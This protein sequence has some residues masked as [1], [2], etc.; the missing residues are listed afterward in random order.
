LTY[1]PQV[2]D[3]VDNLGLVKAEGLLG[4]EGVEQPQELVQIVFQ[5]LPF[6]KDYKAKMFQAILMTTFSSSLFV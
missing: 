4:G 1:L 3:E 5:A 6:I 2:V